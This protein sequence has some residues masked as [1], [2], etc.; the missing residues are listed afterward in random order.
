[1]FIF[2][3][4]HHEELG[5]LLLLE[6]ITLE[7]TDYQEAAIAFDAAVYTERIYFFADISPIE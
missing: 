2:S 6:N 5:D 7:L 3:L 4:S 1:M